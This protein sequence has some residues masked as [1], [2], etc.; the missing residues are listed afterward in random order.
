MARPE[1]GDSTLEIAEVEKSFPAPPRSSPRSSPRVSKTLPPL[2]PAIDTRNSGDGVPA[3]DSPRSPTSTFRTYSPM[4]GI[5]P[6]DVALPPFARPMTPTRAPRPPMPDDSP[7]PMTASTKRLSFS[8]AGVERGLKYGK[9]KH[10]GIELSPQPSDDPQDPLN[11]PLWR[12]HLNFA[13]LLVMVAL[14]GAMKT[15]YISV[16]SFIAIE[17]GVSYTAAVALTGAPLIISAATGMA[18]TVIARIWGKRPVYLVS[19]ILIFIGVVWNT[20]VNGRVGENMAARVFQGM[21]W[22]AFDT[23]VLGSIQDTYFEHQRQ[24]KILIYYVVSVATTWGSPLLGGIA[25]S[26][27]AGFAVQFEIISCFMTIA[28]PL[29]V[30]GVPETTFDRSSLDAAPPT[31]AR[32]QSFWPG[33]TLTKKAALDYIGKMKPWSYKAKTIDPALIM[34]APRAM[35]APS[36]LLLFVATLIPHAGL[37]GLASSVSLLFSPMPFVLPEAI[38][39][40]LMV[41]PFILATTTALASGLSCFQRR[42]TPTVHL[43]ALAMGT[44]L[45]SVGLLGFGLYLEGL[46]RMPA[47]GPRNPTSTLWDLRFVG[48]RI[49]FP[50]VSLLLGLLAAGSVALDDAAAP[51]VRRSTAF[52]SANVAVGLRNTADMHAGLACLRSVAAG[53]FVIG[54]PN[55]VWAWDGLRATALGMGVTQVFLGA[56]LCAVWWYWDEDI[57]RLD[58]RVMGLVHLSDLKDLRQMSF[59]ERK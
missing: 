30:F 53:A 51:V 2:P 13:A 10:S 28:I 45:A 52:T 12:K 27:P 37:W 56:A 20:Q 4:P 59:V 23:L 15:A 46:M 5:A 36:T 8:S 38:L 41:G 18:S 43:T 48:E 21:G 17:E 39:G 54:V 42:F 35:V 26:G 7:R 31:L 49:S 16:D 9:G 32:S 44:A 34:Q 55:A 33:R 22:G 57:R 3:R 19:T 47:D 14:V 29:I 58:G 25:S 11:W 50:V 24:S 6:G 1:S 40:A